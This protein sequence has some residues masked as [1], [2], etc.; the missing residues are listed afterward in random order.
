MA[1]AIHDALNSPALKGVVIA[2]NLWKSTFG[3]LF[4]LA[5]GIIGGVFNA[6][7][8]VAEKTCGLPFGLR[9]PYC[10]ARDIA[11][12]YAPDII[13]AVTTLLIP[14]PFSTNM[15]GGRTFNM[16]AGG[17]DVS[18]NDY[19]HTGLGGQA[20]TDQ[21]VADI[22]NEQ[23]TEDRLAFQNKSV[24]TRMFDTNNSNSA[25]SQVAMAIPLDFKST[26]ASR[27]MSTVLNPVK[28][29]SSLL[30]GFSMKP[31][32]A[33]D[34]PS[35]DPF[36]VVQYGYPNGSIPDD[37][38]A[39]W[40]ANCKDDAS[41]A[42]QNDKNFN[43]PNKKSWNQQAADNIDPGTQ[44]PKNEE[45]NACMLIKDTVGVA[46]GAYDTSLLTDDDLKD[47]GGG[48]SGTSSDSTTEISGNAQELAKKIIDSGN[49]TGDSRYMQQIKDVAAG[50]TGCNVNPDILKMLVGVAVNDNHKLFISSLNRK[51]TGVVVG[52]GTNSFHYADGGGH[53]I[54]VTSFDG[55]TVTGGN[56]ATKKYLDAASK[57][58]PEGTG[59]GQVDSCGSGF[60]IP[61]GSSAVKDSCDHQHIQV[62]KK[63]M[64]GS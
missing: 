50:K 32:F 56:T 24:F 34:K 16:M 43:D 27:L 30:N 62:P 2:S 8:F 20:L 59:Y 44:M 12:E 28:T 11:N 54:D 40:D 53:A 37:P 21:Q 64:S 36:G 60:K 3:Q 10:D 38:E 57:Y 45:V 4:N 61:D 1:N 7:T 52:A 22:R 26:F 58:L 15:S 42:Y 41:Q 9:S 29:F 63:Q 25:V 51:C 13:N 6:Y 47:V 49:V 35:K 31:A 5:D 55:E 46:G 14:N 33:A 48:S 18:G 39:Y 23:I 17:A 19:A